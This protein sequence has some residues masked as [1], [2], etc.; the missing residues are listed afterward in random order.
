MATFAA[1]AVDLIIWLKLLCLGYGKSHCNIF[2]WQLI[3][4]EKKKKFYWLNSVVTVTRPALYSTPVVAKNRLSLVVGFLVCLLRHPVL[5]KDPW[6][7]LSPGLSW[8]FGLPNLNA[9]CK[10]KDKNVNCPSQQ[11]LE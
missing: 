3:K 4:Q 6:I 11:K 10:S 1:A 5:F 8:M 2:K 9:N 7:P